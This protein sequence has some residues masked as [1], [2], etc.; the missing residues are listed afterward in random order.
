MCWETGWGGNSI[1]ET[2][3][4]LWGSLWGRRQL[5]G[6][7]W[8]RRQWCGGTPSRPSLEAFPAALPC[9]PPCGPRGPP[10][11]PSQQPSL[12]SLPRGLPSSLPSWPSL[13]AFSRA[14][15]VALGCRAVAGASRGHSR[16]GLCTHAPCS[17]VTCVPRTALPLWPMS[18]ACSPVLLGCKISARLWEAPSETETGNRTG[19]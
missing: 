2:E 7:Q 3:K 11:Q 16:A 9:G 6:R 17:R 8:G 19:C 12:V 18:P 14:L 1:V 13:A 15:L 10:S 5:W 4:R